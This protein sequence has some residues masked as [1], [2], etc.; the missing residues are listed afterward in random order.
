MLTHP[1]PV[2]VPQLIMEFVVKTQF[3]QILVKIIIVAN[4]PINVKMEVLIAMDTVFAQFSTQ[5]PNVKY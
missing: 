5:V 2:Y 3:K 4:Q 1:T